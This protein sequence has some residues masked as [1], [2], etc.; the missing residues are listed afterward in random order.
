MA[1]RQMQAILHFFRL[2]PSGLPGAWPHEASTNWAG[3]GGFSTWGFF[4]GHTMVA[5]LAI[6]VGKDGTDAELRPKRVRT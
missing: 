3:I 1:T 2:F 5:P 4:R 6:S